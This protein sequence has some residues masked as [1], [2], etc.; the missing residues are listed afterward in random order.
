MS[1]DPEQEYFSDGIS[2]ELLNLLAQIPEL[3]VIS[4][5]S[6]FSFK[7]KDI[8]IPTVA[9]QLNVAH[10]LEG[11]VRKAGNRVRITAQL[12][13]ARSDTHLWSEIYDRTLDDIFA[14]QDEIAA[15]IS[16]ALKLKLALIAGKAALPTA[17]K[18]TNADAYDAYLQGRESIHHGG[19]EA[20]EDAVHH[21]ER[22][23]LLDYNFA[24]AHA[25]LAIATMLLTTHVAAPRRRQG[26]PPFCT[27][28][29][30]RRLN[31]TWPR[32]MW[33][34]RYSHI[35]PT[36]MNPRSSMPAKH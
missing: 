36:I 35:I 27:W 34:G 20:M 19:R 28:T 4:R 5:S 17:I 26:E 13:E 32:H 22:S 9:K 30:L 2:E 18:A 25:Q 31:P 15:A 16:D 33:A 24:P 1:A 29:E 10:V 23:L 7:G 3:R 14:V 11:S 21:L 8:A 6:A 12:I